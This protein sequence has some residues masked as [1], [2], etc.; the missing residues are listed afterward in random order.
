MLFISK[1]KTVYAGIYSGDRAFEG[2]CF[3][4]RKTAEAVSEK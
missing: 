3:P 4:A 2:C 1:Q